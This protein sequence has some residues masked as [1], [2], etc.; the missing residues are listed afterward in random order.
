MIKS[1]HTLV[2]GN[3][4]H[5]STVNYFLTNLAVLVL[6]SFQIV[7]YCIFNRH[8]LQ[9]SFVFFTHLT[10][11]TLS[12]IEDH[13]DNSDAQNDMYHDQCDDCSL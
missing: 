12:D 11:I 7:V 10:C 6:L 9:V 4:M 8:F 13:F 5:G 3:A 1:F 2:A